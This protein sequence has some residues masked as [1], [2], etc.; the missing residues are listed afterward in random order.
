MPG[1]WS[2]EPWVWSL[3][4][5]FSRAFG[6]FA[7][8]RGTNIVR[9]PTFFR[10]CGPCASF[11]VARSV[12]LVQSD[13]APNSGKHRFAAEFAQ[14]FCCANM[15]PHPQITEFEVRFEYLFKQL[16]RYLP[17]MCKL[18]EV[19]RS[20]VEKLE[21]AVRAKNQSLKLGEQRV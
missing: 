9:K 19:A 3:K 13:R 2:L 8:K 20:K 12:A 14:F 16:T 15:S 7:F 21:N 6:S 10:V 11:R 5:E 17:Q 4:L 1:V 18:R